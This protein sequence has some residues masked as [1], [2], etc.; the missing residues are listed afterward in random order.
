VHPEHRRLDR[1]LT[2]T[3]V[4]LVLVEKPMT[5]PG[6]P[7]L[8]DEIVTASDAASAVVLYDFPELYDPLTHRI[9]EYLHEF[10]SVELTSIYVQRSKDREDPANP[11]NRKRMVDIQYQES[12]HCLAFALFMI[13]TVAGNLQA[14]VSRGV[15]LSGES[16]PYTPPNP[17]DYLA[18]V[19]GRCAFRGDLGGVSITGLTDFTRGAPWAKQRILRG[20]GDGIPFEIDVSYLEGNK[21]L[22]INGLPQDC[23]PAANSYESVLATA[24]RWVRQIPREQLKTGLYP[25]PRFTRMTYHLSAML[26]Q[27]CRDPG[28]DLAWVWRD[29]PKKDS[30]PTSR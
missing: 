12:V 19:D 20:R 27:A 28:Q 18:P 7:D 17:E 11:R 23:D 30:A 14:V 10:R 22:C 29:S 16:S 8:C 1:L 15:R 26:W 5:V 13:A 4:P 2:R 25:N 9:I 3:D 21:S 24:H 6:R